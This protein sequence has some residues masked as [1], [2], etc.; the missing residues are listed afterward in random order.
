MGGHQHHS[1]FL[2][3]E[4][5]QTPWQLRVGVENISCMLH[6]KRLRTYLARTV[7]KSLKIHFATSTEVQALKFL[8][9]LFL[10][11]LVDLVV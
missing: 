10:F 9:K 5:E 8:K 2:E 6:L 4:I 1:F 11:C 3:Q 7:C